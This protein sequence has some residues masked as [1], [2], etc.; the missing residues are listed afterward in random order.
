MSGFR[1]PLTFPSLER[2]V[3]QRLDA[4]ISDEEVYHVM[5]AM[6]PWKVL[7]SDGFPASF[8]QKSWKVVENKICEFVCKVWD[9]PCQIALVNQTGIFLIPNV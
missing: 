1:L 7:G 4:Q 6:K 9:N 2:D 5:F 3:Y 8:C